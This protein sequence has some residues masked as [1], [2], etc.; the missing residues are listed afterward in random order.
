MIADA[1]LDITTTVRERVSSKPSLVLCSSKTLDLELQNLSNF[2]GR[3]Y[4]LAAF[5][6]TSHPNYFTIDTALHGSSAVH[7]PF[8]VE[9]INGRIDMDSFHLDD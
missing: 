3:R 2:A 8:V 1:S 9:Q 6:R 4:F 7:P 5:L